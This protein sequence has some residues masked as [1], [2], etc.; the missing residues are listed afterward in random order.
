MAPNWFMPHYFWIGF[1][2]VL[3]GVLGGM[4]F[5]FF[6]RAQ[7]HRAWV[8]STIRAYAVT[9]RESDPYVR[10]HLEA[11]D[12]VERVKLPRLALCMFLQRNPWQV[13]PLSVLQ[14]MRHIED[15]V[16]AAVRG[17]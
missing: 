17:L 10:Q 16:P 7:M 14:Y 11:L 6:D 8:R 12:D 13:Y 5:S 9:Y 15:K 4:V 2:C 1:A 3:M